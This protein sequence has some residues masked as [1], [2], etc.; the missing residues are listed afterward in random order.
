MITQHTAGVLI[1]EEPHPVYISFCLL[2]S[3][4][5]DDAGRGNGLA[6]H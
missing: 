4:R 6:S 5:A 3:S 2:E 1:K